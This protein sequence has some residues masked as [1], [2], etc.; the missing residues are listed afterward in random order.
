MISRSTTGEIFS[1]TI[2]SRFADVLGI[3]VDML[4]DGTRIPGR[5]AILEPV[6]DNITYT[7]SQQRAFRQA[8]ECVF[9]EG[10][11]G[12]SF[13][14]NVSK[15]IPSTGVWAH[16]GSLLMITPTPDCDDEFFTS[17]SNTADD[18]A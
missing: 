18:P 15:K 7:E 17:M 11:D 13:A 5:V 1:A 16:D 3:G 12:N 6:D 2:N 8:F 10:Y 9:E 4:V 14:I